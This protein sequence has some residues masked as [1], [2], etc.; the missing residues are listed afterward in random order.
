[1]NEVARRTLIE[2][3]GAIGGSRRRGCAESPRRSGASCCFSMLDGDRYCCGGK[4][5]PPGPI[6]PGYGALKRQKVPLVAP[7]RKMSQFSGPPNA[8]FVVERSPFGTGT[9]A[10][11]DAA[12]IPTAVRAWSGQ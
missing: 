9:K 10:D 2:A 7:S 4:R 11:D 5:T 12:N 6:R 1:M 8:K 3:A